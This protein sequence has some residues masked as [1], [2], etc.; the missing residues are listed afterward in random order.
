[1]KTKKII[2]LIND[3]CTNAKMVSVKGC[4]SSSTDHCYDEDY[5]KCQVYSIDICVVKDL[6]ACY[7][8]S[9]DV[10]AIGEDTAACINYTQDYT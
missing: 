5:A 3:E 9:E 8:Y 6:A 2:K 4:D 1:M 10:C 7:N